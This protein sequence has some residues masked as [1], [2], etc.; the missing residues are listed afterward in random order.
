MGADKLSNGFKIKTLLGKVVTV[1]SYIAGGG[2]GDVYVVDYNGTDKAL[3]WY[4]PNG[5]GKK[6]TAFYE[7][8]K[9]NVMR[10]A[11]SAE[12]LW[13]LDT[14]EWV[15][16]TFGYIMELRP[17]DYFEVSHFMLK[18]V[19]FKNY[20][21]AVDAALQ[22][23]SAFRILHNLGY[24]YQDM[25]DGN[26]FINPNN[27]KVLICDNDNVAPNGTDTGILGKPRYMA[28][29][30][31]LGKKMPDNLTDR[32][33]M[34]II[35][36][37]L[38]CMNH[39]LEGKRSLV[40]CLTPEVQKKLYGSEPLFIMDPLDKSNA[41]D[42]RVHVNL[43]AVWPCLPVYM[44]ELFLKAFSKQSFENPNARPKELDWIK[45]LVRFRSEIVAC[46][47]CQQKNDYNDIFTEQGR[48]CKCDKCGK[49]LVIPYRLEFA[50]Y[51]VPAIYDSRIYR[52]QLGP[53]NADDAL[54][55]VARIAYNDPSRPNS[56]SIKNLT[57]GVWNAVTPSGK[58]K[59]VKSK[60]FIPLI[61]GIKFVIKNEEI[62][63]KSN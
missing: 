9:N 36:F 40:P 29:E 58:D 56:L 43:R 31:V 45:T 16:G 62:T 25:N 59:H 52:C 26:F 3:K 61:D 8:I 48:S 57:E 17:K 54:T 13:P 46:P 51:S 6:P 42:P 1:K 47:M 19:V 18:K 60:E 44:Q 50:E 30:I 49:E 55:P 11:P 20:K 37:I 27:G 22:I 24:S 41:P 7:N 5:M 4:K 15:N 33:S 21:V 63:I 34:S 23:V 10:G 14:T 53:C 38:F 2:Q 32:F 12:F 35:L 28:P 39:P